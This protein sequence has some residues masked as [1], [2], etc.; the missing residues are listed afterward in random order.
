MLRR[1]DLT[2]ST[3]GETKLTPRKGRGAGIA[4]P[5]ITTYIW[6]PGMGKQDHPLPGV[7]CPKLWISIDPNSG[8][9]YMQKSIYRAA[10]IAVTGRFAPLTF[11]PFTGRFAPVRFATWT[12]CPLTGR[13]ATD[14]GRFAPVCFSMCLLFFRT[15]ERD[16]RVDRQNCYQYLA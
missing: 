15:P 8:T 5:Y 7:V 9:L 11:C 6:A 4:R 3:C 1:S 12:F 10:G 14:Y 2:Q 13:F 16:G